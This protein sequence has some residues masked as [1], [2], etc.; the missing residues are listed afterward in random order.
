L[1]GYKFFFLNDPNW[2]PPAAG[3]PPGP[4][5]LLLL[6]VGRMFFFVSLG[7]ELMEWIWTFI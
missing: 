4:G 5:S 1:V 6:G 7:K 2:P 3:N